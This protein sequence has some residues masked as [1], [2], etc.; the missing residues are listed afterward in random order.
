MWFSWAVLVNTLWD[1]SV[2]WHN[3]KGFFSHLSVTWV[4]RIEL[5]TFL[6]PFSLS[7]CGSFLRFSL[8]WCF[9]NSWIS[10]LV[11]RIA[12]GICPGRECEWE[13]ASKRKRPYYFQRFSLEVHISAASVHCR[14]H[15][16]QRGEV[17]AAFQA[18]EYQRI[19][20]HIFKPPIFHRKM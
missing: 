3:L 8:A 4:G 14:S 6:G 20:G 18:Q 9:Q 10:Y 2:G 12:K 1:Y 17:D 13:W 16:I 7:L 19:R 15:K 11:A 5:L